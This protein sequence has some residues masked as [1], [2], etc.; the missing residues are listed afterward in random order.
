MREALDTIVL[1]GT[2]YVGGELLRLIATHPRFRLKAAISE[3]QA[4]NTIEQVFPHL[5]QSFA[6]C[7]FVHPESIS[8]VVSG[9]ERAAVF[10]AAPHGAS[11]AMVDA[12][13]NAAEHASSTVRVVDL[14]ADFRFATLDAYEAVYGSG[15]GAPHRLESF[16]CA[17]PEHLAAT[18][19]HVGHPGCFSTAVLLAVVPMRQLG[20]SGEDV[21]VA[22]VTGSTGA[23]KTPTG[24]THHPFR[25]SNLFAY[26]P[27]VHRHQPEMESICRAVSGSAVALHFVPHSGPFARGIHVTAQGRLTEPLNAAELADRLT[28]FYEDAPF[29][30]VIQETPRVKD[31]VGSNFARIGVATRGAHFALMVVIDNLVKGAAG[32]AVQWMN[33]LWGHPES[34]GL[35]APGAGWT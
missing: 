26:K 29:V 15:H 14:S 28:S 13:L 3:S 23:G 1:G 4:G 30:S 17:L 24:T 22:G 27:L 6:G 16:T 20:L 2:G 34:A 35:E 25:H 10:S 5:H 8:Q 11:A 33:R 32:G 31:V 12:V 9:L 19:P 21:F 18:P 7:C